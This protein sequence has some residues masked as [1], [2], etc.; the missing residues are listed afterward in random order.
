MALRDG[1][2]HRGIDLRI[3]EVA[4]ESKLTETVASIAKQVGADEIHIGR[5]FG[6]DEERRDEAV[7]HHAKLPFP[8][9]GALRREGEKPRDLQR[10]SSM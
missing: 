10:V 8:F 9:G 6:V 1:L 5:E 7:D 4:D 3:V 2:R